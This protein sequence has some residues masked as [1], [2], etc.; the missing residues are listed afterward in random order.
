MQKIPLFL[1]F[2]GHIWV[3]ASQGILPVVLP[4]LKELL[5]LS[6]FQVGLVMAVLNITASVIQPVFGYIADR[7]RSGWFIPWGVI[8]TAV[9]MGM[10][11]WAP[12]Y[13]SILILVGLA[14]LGTAAF[15]PRAMM[16]VF[17]VSGMRKGLGQA[18]F[19]TG[20]NAG[21]ALGP[22]VG[23]FLVLGFGIHATVGLVIPGV[24]LALVIIFYPGDS[25]RREAA[26][27]GGASE[28]QTQATNAID[29]VSL[30][31]VC[32][33]VTLRSWVYITFITYLPM[34]WETQGILLGT[35]SL[36]LT[37]FL[38]AGAAA[39]LYGGHLSDRLGPRGVIIVSM[40]LYPLFASLM[41]L[42]NGVWLWFFVAASGAALLCS[43]SVT[44]ILTQKILPGH[45][46]LASGLTLGLGFGTGGLGAALSGWMADAMGLAN[47]MWV[48]A[49]VPS[50]ASLFA[51]LTKTPP[52]PRKS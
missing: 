23:S 15:H 37:L 19:A 43:F 1:L 39:G 9:T 52:S 49:L 47:T 30:V 27:S 44:V 12:G 36:L 46:G 4:K 3:D 24:L 34:F 10:L 11:G 42:G 25:L 5:E 13:G 32:L 8:W 29:W 28:L 35:G 31:L 50:L 26:K 7:F 45:L 17:W 41:L 40:L 48:L 38:G 33:I 51:A 21:F 14:G 2:L 16:A 20:G 6:Y 18:I 22:I